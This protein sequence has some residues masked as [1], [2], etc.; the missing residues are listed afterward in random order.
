MGAINSRRLVRPFELDPRFFLF[1]GGKLLAISVGAVFVV[2]FVVKGF[3][4]VFRW[5]SAVEGYNAGLR[6]RV[7]GCLSPIGVVFMF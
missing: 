4:F 3:F 1:S 6:S 5:L 2:C 7:F